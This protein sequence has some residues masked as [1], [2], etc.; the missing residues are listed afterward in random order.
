MIFTTIL[1]K[2]C[3]KKDD[4]DLSKLFSTDVLNQTI[5][6]TDQTDKSEGYKDSRLKIYYYLDELSIFFNKKSPQNILET[7][8]LITQTPDCIFFIIERPAK[9]NFVKLIFI[10]EMFNDVDV[11]KHLSLILNQYFNEKNFLYSKARITF[12]YNKNINNNVLIAENEN[13]KVNDLR[14]NLLMLKSSNLLELSTYF[15]LNLGPNLPIKFTIQDK[16]ILEKKLKLRTVWLDK[17]NINYKKKLTYV[18]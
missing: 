2:Y 10:T 3:V 8:S 1:Y 17:P 4:F 6:Y 18:S 15:N 7:L 9:Y 13:I 14:E 12:L 5:A 16:T 11:K